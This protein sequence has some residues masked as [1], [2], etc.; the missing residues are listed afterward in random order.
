MQEQLPRRGS[1]EDAALVQQIP[2][3]AG[4][5]IICGGR[6]SGGRPIRKILLI[7]IHHNAAAKAAL[8]D[9]LVSA[10]HF[11]KAKAVGN[12]VL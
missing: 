3:C 6:P 7:N 4:M 12:T 2:A 8:L 9:Q 11:I 1:S 5:T 10:R